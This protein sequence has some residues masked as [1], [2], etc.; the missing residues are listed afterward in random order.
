MQNYDY[1]TDPR[2]CCTTLAAGKWGNAKLYCCKID[3]TKWVVKDFNSCPTPIAS[4]WGRLLI[5]R[6]FSALTE[7]QGIEGVP[8]QPFKIDHKTLCYRY[9][10]GETLRYIEAQKIP[11]DFFPKLE[12]VVKQIHACNYAHLDL[13]NRRNI[14]L[15]SDGSP[16]L[17]DF[18][19]AV[20]L[21]RLPAAVRNRIQLVDLSG[22]YKAWLKLS[23]ATI[24]EKRLQILHRINS[25]RFLWVL[26]GYPLQRWWKRRK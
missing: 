9:Q 13:R 21:S 24:D 19:T 8:T 14:L 5:H 3:S 12:Y 6:E 16:G 7:L 4:T 10:S 26:R 17:L 22:I 15:R 11:A 18:Q 20:N 23:P 1:V 25:K 2:H